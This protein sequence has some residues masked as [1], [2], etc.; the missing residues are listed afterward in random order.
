MSSE[1][2]LPKIALAGNPNCGKTSLFNALTGGRQKVGNY[3]GVTVERKEGRITSPSGKSLVLLDL[4]GTY[5][6][7]ARTPD[8]A[9]TRD[10]VL[11]KLKEE[12]APDLVIAVADATC[13]ERSLGLVIELRE[14]GLPTVLALN[15]MDLART[16][17]ME[18][19][20]DALT[21]ELGIP[22]IPTVAT[23]KQ[24]TRDL[25]AEAEKRLASHTVS[26]KE[27]VWLKPTPDQVRARFAEVDRVLRVALKRAAGP[28]LW[29]D[30]LDRVLLHP[31]WGFLI[32]AVVLAVVFQS[33][34]NWASVPQDLIKNGLAS[35]GKLVEG[36]MAAG[37][38]RSLLVD[39]IIA[40]VGSVLVF[41]P[42][43]LL[44]FLFILLL[45]DSGYMARAA[46]LMDRMM[47]RVGLH[48]RA[49]IPLLSSFACAIP[50]IMATRT[51]ENPRDRLTTILVAPLMTCSARLPV[52]SLIIAAFIPNRVVWGP[53]KLQ[54][55]VMLALYVAAVVIALAVAML[56]KRTVL[57][58]ANPPLLM[59]LPTYKVPSIL[60]V[61]VG[62]L[63][64]A[65][66]FLRR[67]GTVILTLMVMLWFLSSYPQAPAGSTA[68][69]IEYSFAGRLGHVIEPILKPIGFNW[70]I[71]IALIPGFAAREVMVGALATVYAVEAK[72]DS[73]TQALGEALAKDWTLATALSLLAW[74]VI[75]MQCASTLAVTRRET[76]SW[77][78]P[79][80]M[81]VYMTVLAYGASYA[82]YRIACGLGL[83]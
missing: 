67:A 11:G 63:E 46:F 40:G 15:M 35:L 43:I 25:I 69:A 81:F 52:Y 71:S 73:G 28:T 14:I 36:M 24:G 21:R 5:S 55:L 37:P 10:V 59:E 82:T 65:K 45:E 32:L 76:N 53:F 57:S 80:V 3:P 75:S 30:R 61:F 79:V 68:P 13:L 12:A 50:G 26:G 49:F 51:I 34:F 8:E 83:G 18:L 77:K 48:G 62:L 7:D 22:V 64:R 56:L 70:R 41:L 4:P 1:A 27:P 78:W 23:R 74:Y 72:E 2:V 29:T 42:Q 31:F 9:V 60:G 20:L 17:G 39:G 6:L 47:G 58:G 38:L 54:G 16:R 19:D 44:L 33:I 66:L